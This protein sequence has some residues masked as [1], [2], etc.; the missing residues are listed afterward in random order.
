M[1][2]SEPINIAGGMT[3]LTITPQPTLHSESHLNATSQN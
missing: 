3:I 1:L 2:K